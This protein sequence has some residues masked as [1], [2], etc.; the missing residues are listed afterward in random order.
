MGILQAR[1]LEWIAMPSSGGFSQSRDGARVSCTGRRGSLPLAPPTGKDEP[2]LKP[3]LAVHI[4]FPFTS[5]PMT[6]TTEIIYTVLNVLVHTYIHTSA[7]HFPPVL[8]GGLDDP[9]LT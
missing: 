6:P 1:I 4:E 7:L 3:R 2:G 8:S 9:G 5:N